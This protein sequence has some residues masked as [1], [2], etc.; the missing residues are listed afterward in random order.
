MPHFILLYAVS[1]NAT[2]NFTDDQIVRIGLKH[3]R[4]AFCRT[5]INTATGERI[6]LEVRYL[7]QDTVTLCKPYLSNQK[8]ACKLFG[9]KKTMQSSIGVHDSIIKEDCFY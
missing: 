5:F 3:V 9:I 1:S 6:A 2:T 8:L 4:F 7:R